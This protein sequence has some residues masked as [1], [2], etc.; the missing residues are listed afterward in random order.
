MLLIRRAVAAGSL[1][2][3]FSSGKVEAREEPTEA[4]VREALQEWASS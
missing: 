1:A 4:A 3:S 2:W